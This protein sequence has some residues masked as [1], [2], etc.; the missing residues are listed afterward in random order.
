VKHDQPVMS[1]WTKGYNSA[2]PPK[3]SLLCKK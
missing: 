2:V 1:Y 3:F